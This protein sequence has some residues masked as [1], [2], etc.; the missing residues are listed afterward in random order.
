MSDSS[1]KKKDCW[2][3]LHRLTTIVKKLSL[4][5]NL[6]QVSEIVLQEARAISKSEGATFVLK[7]KEFCFYKDEYSNFP[8]WKGQYLPLDKCICGWAMNEG[9]VVNIPDILLDSRIVQENY[10][11]TSVKGLLVIPILPTNSIGA[12][13]MYWTKVHKP[14]DHTIHLLQAL[15][16]VTAIAIEKVRLYSG[17]EKLVKERT[18]QLEYEIAERKK[19]QD[20]LLQLSLTDALTGL[21]NRRG[22]F[23]QVE[24][25]IKLASRLKTHSFLMFADLDNLKKVNDNYG[26]GAGDEMIANAAKILKGVFRSSDVISRLGGDEFAVFTMETTDHLTI[27]SRIDQAIKDFNESNDYPYPISI[28]I[29]VIELE[30]NSS[31]SLD[32]LLRMAD[33]AMYE[34]KQTKKAKRKDKVKKLKKILAE[35]PSI[36]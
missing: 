4:S 7:E 23:F 35:N 17:L 28:S 29:G 34:D 6:E 19:A 22:F 26:H 3:E 8:L 24:Q 9:K 30:A 1:H 14:N 12:I 5:Q 25:E 27:R 13:G 16:D 32:E 2:E 15:A 18:V 21:L 20:A 10:Q 11:H 36:K 31:Y 33:E